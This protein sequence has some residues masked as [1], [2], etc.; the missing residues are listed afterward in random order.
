[1]PGLMQLLTPS[2]TTPPPPA[3]PTISRNPASLS[4][5]AVQN[6]TTPS[7]QTVTIS[8]IGGSTLS[9]TA[10]STAS[11]LTLNGG[12]SASGTNSGSFATGV[13]INGLAVGTY[14][15][16]IA[17]N[18]T[19]ATNTPQSI[20]VSLTI[21]TAPTPTI[22]LSASNFTFTGVQGGSN[23]STQNLII[24]NTGAGTLSWS[25]SENTSWLTLGTS[26][27]T[28]NGTVALTVNTA[29]MSAGTYSAPMTITATGATN[30]PQIV[31]I[32]L[33]LTAPPI[34]TIT[35]NPS[36]LAFTAAQGGA[37]PTPQTVNV[38]NTGTGTL[39][40]SVSS[41]T[42][43]LS[44]SPASGTAPGSFTVTANVGGLSA[45]T[46]SGSITV[47]GSGASNSPQ[48]IPVTF[49]VTAPTPSLTVN[50][51]SLTFSATQGST[52]PP[53]Q[54][55]SIASNQSWSVSESISWLS[56]SPATGSNNGVVT[57]T[58]DTSTATVG[59]NNGTVTITGG[60]ITRTVTV[61]LNLTAPAATLTVSPSSL[62]FT[63]T[64][65]AANPSNQSLA[66][67]SNS[68][69]TVSDNAS[70]L[71]V[72]PT[73]AS[74]NGNLN[75]SVNTA[76][77]VVGINTA[78]ITVTGGGITRTV[79][80]TLNL[81]APSTSSAT[82]TWTPNAEPDLASYRVYRSTTQGVYGPA[83]A[84]VPAGTAMY[85]ATGLNVATTYFFRITA[86][87]S[88]NNESQPSN[89]VSKVIP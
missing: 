83:I 89:E 48:T 81:N 77:A 41:T 5:S 50:P 1:M 35:L 54:S 78:T 4:F 37:N 11:W 23:P 33:I 63:A 10:S 58:V 74:N 62:T 70:W 87:D 39:S 30:T 14:S 60:G 59:A 19:G 20:G 12:S 82:L 69:W 40:W 15:G 34:P 6:G 44:I 43:W 66:V 76:T 56:V 3:G 85:T 25:V 51:A 55:L 28:G 7:P 53:G 2:T 86:V 42:P 64:Q 71:T 75:V 27:G 65:G 31:T 88:A 80:V 72:S 73:S 52:N 32:T 8:N 67:T 21:T 36:T 16:S 79:A 68:S 13:N 57:V 38:S 46:H 18:A 61:I 45:A 29:G 9:W 17:I 49:T 26:S 24:S 84:T 47:M 22:G